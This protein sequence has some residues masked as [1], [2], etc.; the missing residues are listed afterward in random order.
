M[1]CLMDV[2]SKA[3][4]YAQANPIGSSV[5]FGVLY[6]G[7]PYFHAVFKKQK[8]RKYKKRS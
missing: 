4:K 6:E 2:D 7:I 1:G 8:R 5:G 3:A